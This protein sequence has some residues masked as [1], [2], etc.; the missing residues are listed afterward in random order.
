M[1]TGCRSTSSC[2]P[3][4]ASQRLAPEK[5]ARRRSARPW[6]GLRSSIEEAAEPTLR[7]KKRAKLRAGRPVDADDRRRRRRDR[8]RHPRPSARL[9]GGYRPAS[10]STI[11]PSA[12]SRTRQRVLPSAKPPLMREHRL[13]QADWLMRFYGFDRARDRR[14]TARRHARPRDRSQARLGA[15]QSRRLPGRR[16][17]APTARCCCACRAWARKASTASSPR[18]ATGGCGS[19]MSAG[20]A[21][22]SPRCGPSSSPTAGRRAALT[23]ARATCAHGWR[24]SRR[25]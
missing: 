5:D 10:A 20:S 3:T 12:R 16:Q 21:S 1:P 23:D 19:R 4:R 25:S 7:T 11:P 6:R 9:Y 24:R 2:R 14:R 15:A 13:Y 8:R 22:R 17:P 18:A